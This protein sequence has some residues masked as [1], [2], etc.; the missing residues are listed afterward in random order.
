M[1]NGIII[2]IGDNRLMPKK[3]QQLKYMLIL[4]I[5]IFLMIPPINSNDNHR[6]VQSDQITPDISLFN[7]NLPPNTSIGT[8]EEYQELYPY[9]QSMFTNHFSR[10]API[11]QTSYL[12]ILV[13]H[14][15]Y[16]S[17]IA[18]KINQYIQ[19]LESKEYIVLSLD[20]LKGGNP[21]EVK[22]WVKNQYQTGSNG[23][24]FIGDIPAAWATISSETFPCDLFYMDIDGLWIDG[25]NDDIFEE[26]TDGSGDMGPELY[27]ARLFSSSLNYNTEKNMIS[28]YF[29]KIQDYN[30]GALSVPW[31]GLEYIDEDWFDMNVNLN[32]IFD[33]DISHYDFGHLTTGQDYIAKL[34][35]GHQFVTVCAHSYPGGH[36]FGK[37]PTEAVTYMHTYVYSP[38]QRNAKLLLGSDDG[39]MVYFNGKLVLEKDIY[40][41]WVPDQYRV[42]VELNQGWNQLLC[43]VSQKN[44]DYEISA[45][46]TDDQYNSYTDLSYQINNPAEMG[47][48]GEF[49]RGWLINGFHQDSSDAFWNY[50]ST[51][52]L[53][54]EESTIKP[55]EGDIMDGK[56][57]E[58]FSSNYPYI[59]LDEY[60][61]GS[62]FGVTYAY[63][64]IH[65][66]Q[67]V[68]CELWVGYDDGIRAWL[69]GEEIILDN[70]YGEYISDMTKT[71]VE[72]QSGENHLLIKVSE[73]MGGHGF[74]A[75]FC[76]ENG[77]KIDGLSYNP[78]PEPISYISNWLILDPFE[79]EDEENRLT[80]EYI[81][82]ESTLSPSNGEQMGSR[83]WNEAVG[84]GRPF[85]IA[86]FFDHG[87]WVYS[88]TIQEIDPPVLFYNL[89]A[90]S[91]GR[92]PDQN[93][94]AG[95][96]IFN[97]SYG[98][99]TVASAKSGSM[100]NFQD[101]T[102][103]LGE[104]N[105]IG[106]AFL[107]WFEAQAPFAQW[108]QEWYYGMSL[109]GDPTLSL[110]QTDNP[111][112]SIEITHPN[113]GIY[114]GNTRILPFFAPVL[115]GD[116]S[117]TVE[118]INP[119]FG[120]ENITFLVNDEIRSVDNEP[121]F[122]FMMTDT[123]FG[124][125]SIQAI[126]VDS[127]G[128]SDSESLQLWKFF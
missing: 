109:F 105:D 10:L 34:E 113:T 14:N 106:T 7:L 70:R 80:Y 126:A 100:L 31:R 111:V 75:R 21:A 96:Y 127:Q 9:N 95:S 2:T 25:D 64:T 22:D 23:V 3:N 42:D 83:T 19:Q 65:A 72:L 15:L 17:E 37:R 38:S 56:S 58:L 74:S 55:S 26:H 98:L 115:I 13:E 50:L 90:C 6:N 78:V 112:L 41:G 52:Y 51:N 5:T 40:R 94:L 110:S 47:R 61:D 116:G 104:G 66:N 128:N 122:E 28:D 93:Y 29:D 60:G 82:D 12:S 71:P 117:I 107:D 11:G 118:I 92:F 125:Q 124:V 101:F 63:S 53:D 1:N 86:G 79:H 35:Q 45:R 39:I 77:E 4:I 103:S 48:Q 108:E 8:F 67:Q 89:F 57:W 81:Q 27:I 99:V 59:D 119:G 36:H 30:N 54:V 46:F 85:D 49:I 123:V 20:T 69:N 120:V 87:D 121:P 114:V 62:D 68:N 73:W 88:E 44:G 84:H 32:E 43:K 18:E 24:L 16:T 33:S 102:S 97:T 76:T 91:A